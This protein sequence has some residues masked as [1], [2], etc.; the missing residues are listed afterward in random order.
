MCAWLISSRNM[1]LRREVF[2]SREEVLP[3]SISQDNV[4][5]PRRFVESRLGI[6]QGNLGLPSPRHHPHQFIHCTLSTL[7]WSVKTQ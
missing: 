6:L 2:G 4:P 1:V 3:S 5:E 7:H